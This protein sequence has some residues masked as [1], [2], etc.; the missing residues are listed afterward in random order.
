MS[1]IPRETIN[2]VLS[3]EGDVREATAPHQAEFPYDRDG[4]A[5]VTRRE[6]CN[7][8]F[9]TSSALLLGTG[10][11]AAKS[12]YDASRSTNHGPMRIEGAAAMEPGTAL[13][14]HYP[15][16]NETAILVRDRAGDY[17]AYGQKCTHLTCPVFYAKESDRL[18]CP[19][20]EGGFDVR[21]GNVLYGPPPRPLD[22]VEVEVR[23]GEVWAVALI[24]GGERENGGGHG[25]V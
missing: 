4:E 20:H 17:H 12:V 19:C 22:K 5:Q 10:G 7:F 18:E 3:D 23:D 6:F 14:F 11:F 13:N 24:R 2:K 8:L 16:E 15:N 21:T 1:S 25:R 9:L